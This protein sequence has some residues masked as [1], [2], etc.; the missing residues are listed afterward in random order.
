MGCTV[1]LGSIVYAEA[2]TDWQ[3]DWGGEGWK[4]YGFFLARK[5]LLEI[6]CLHL[7]G[8]CR[9][10]RKGTLGIKRPRQFSPGPA[11]GRKPGVFQTTI[12]KWVPEQGDGSSRGDD[13]GWRGGLSRSLPLSLS[14]LDL[15]ESN[16]CNLTQ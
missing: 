15:V 3:A 2:G 7:K 1:V 11:S 6:L 14:Q 10:C 4:S 13:G 16:S 5:Y 9:G 12:V 8:G